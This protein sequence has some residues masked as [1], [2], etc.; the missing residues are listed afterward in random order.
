M[1]WVAHLTAALA[2]A[3]LPAVFEAPVEVDAYLAVVQ[4]G[5]VEVLDRALGVA[6]VVELH[7]AEAARRQYVLVQPHHDRAH[8]PHLM[9]G[10]GRRVRGRR[11]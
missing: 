9:K 2:P 10:S 6:A 4:L 1:S 7:E 5:A 8:H 11:A 3:K